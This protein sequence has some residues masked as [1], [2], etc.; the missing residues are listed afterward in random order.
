MYLQGRLH[1][2]DWISDKIQLSEIND[3]FQ[4]MKEGRT[5]RSLIDFGIA[6]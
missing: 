4:A 2:D 1:L 5:V 6:S 3:G